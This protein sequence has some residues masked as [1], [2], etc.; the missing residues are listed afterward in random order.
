MSH[1][2][3]D[4]RIDSVSHLPIIGSYSDLSTTQLEEEIDKMISRQC[5]PPV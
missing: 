3:A 1:I 4:N 2:S 5:S